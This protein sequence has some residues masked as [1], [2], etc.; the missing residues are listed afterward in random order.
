MKTHKLGWKD[1]RT[2]SSSWFCALFSQP[3]SFTREPRTVNSDQ[4]TNGTYTS[5]PYRSVINRVPGFGIIVNKIRGREIKNRKP[6][7]VVLRECGLTRE[8]CVC[9]ERAANNKQ[10]RSQASQCVVGY[11][12]SINSPAR[13]IE[14]LTTPS[15]GS[16]PRLL[17]ITGAVNQFW[18]ADRLVFNANRCLRI[19]K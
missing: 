19:Q 4:S 8:T 3:T 16:E 12:A 1:S 7:V 15:N 17:I 11:T 10:R 14:R 18:A 13:A 5:F 9:K 2:F 6:F